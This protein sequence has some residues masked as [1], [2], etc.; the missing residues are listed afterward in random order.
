MPEGNTT[1]GG[2]V[3][4]GYMLEIISD[5]TEE[6]IALGRQIGQLL[7]PG[8]VVLLKGDLGAGKTHFSKGVALGLGIN[9]TITSPTFTLINEYQGRWPLYHMDFYRLGE[10]E[11]AIDLGV[12]EYFYGQ[13]VCLLEWPEQILGFWPEQFLEITFQ[14][15]NENG[16][17]ISLDARGRQYESLLEELKKNVH[18]GH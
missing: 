3:Y 12:D 11:E 17:R 8:A 14:T 15:I 4:G 13:G 7:R 10:P 16:R 2:T 6:T 9:E 18:S 5:S 1:F